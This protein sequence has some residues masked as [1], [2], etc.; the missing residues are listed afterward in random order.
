MSA[1]VLDTIE[2][3][4]QSEPRSPK[5]AS[6]EK[7]LVTIIG[8]EENMSDV[9]LMVS[10]SLL[11]SELHKQDDNSSQTMVSHDNVIVPSPVLPR[12]LGPEPSDCHERMCRDPRQCSLNNEKLAKETVD[13]PSGDSGNINMNHTVPALKRKCIYGK[14]KDHRIEKVVLRLNHEAVGN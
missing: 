9:H 8:V 6:P 1:V 13:Q 2:D 10:L 5:L 12:S 3:I 4:T 7:T 14:T 11:S